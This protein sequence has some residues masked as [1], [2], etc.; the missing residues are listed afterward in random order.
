MVEPAPVSQSD[1]VDEASQR[2]SPQIAGAVMRFGRFLRHV[3]LRRG[4]SGQDVEDVLQELRVRLGRTRSSGETSRALG[5]SYVYRTAV[6]AALEV[7]RQ[8]RAGAGLSGDAT[9]SQASEGIDAADASTLRYGGRDESLAHAEFVRTIADAGR[10]L[11]EPRRVVVRMYLVGYSREDMA[12]ILG[13]SEAKVRNL[14][15]R[16]LADLRAELGRRG[17]GPRDLM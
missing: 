9:D 6:A 10:T 14:L 5:V 8:R 2:L 15:Y 13:W 16:G 11:I 4:L 1:A 12:S 3:V 7:V 17:I